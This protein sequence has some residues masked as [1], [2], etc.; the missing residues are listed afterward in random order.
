[1]AGRIHGAAHFANARCG[2][3]AGFIM[4]HGD[5]L[6]GV[7][8]VFAEPRFDG[9]HIGATAPIGLHEIRHDP[10]AG[11]HFIPQMGEP[12]SFAHQHAVPGG[13]RIGKRR[14]PGAGAAGGV[15]H[16]RTLGLED[17]ARLFQQSLAEDA[18]IR[19][20]MVH[21]GVVHRAQNAVRHIAGTWDLQEVPPGSGL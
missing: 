3:G 14:F 5:G 9:F 13:K 21:G 20:A 16:Y 15:D 7:G 12:A 1:M 4:H 18:K 11:R 2:A 10:K 17:M 19:A 6:D 8:L